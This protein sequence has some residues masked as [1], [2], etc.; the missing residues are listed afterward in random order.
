M[1]GVVMQ[2]L[3]WRLRSEHHFQPRTFSY[4]SV[5]ADLE[6][7]LAR[8][9]RFIGERGDGPVHVVGHSLGGV[10]ALHALAGFSERPPGRLVCLGSPLTGSAAARRLAGW[11][12][13]RTVL[14]ETL[15]RAVLEQPL[16]R[17]PDGL[18]VGVIAGD[19]PVGLG[20]VFPGLPAPNDGVVAVAETRLPGI[21]DHLLVHA[22][23][24]WL[25]FSPEVAAQTAGFL[26][27]GRFRHGTAR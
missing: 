20:L 7:N 1:R 16:A 13:G 27:N 18:E 15:R 12:G 22:S 25:L 23:H 24:S 9:R 2:V 6:T 26:A 5:A 17:C 19:V 4:L 11:P 8:L 14:G 21:R 10:L 3:A